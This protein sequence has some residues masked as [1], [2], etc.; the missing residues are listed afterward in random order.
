LER[1][2]DLLTI[3]LQRAN[4]DLANPHSSVAEN[5][6]KIVGADLASH[7]NL[8]DV[9]R[10]RMVVKVDHPAW[11]Q[12]LQM[13]QRQII[14]EVGRRYPQLGVTR[15]TSVLGK[16]TPARGD[17]PA[18]SPPTRPVPDAEL[19][20]ALRALSEQL[21]RVDGSEDQSDDAG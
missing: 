18:S 2:G 21:H 3:L 17:E 5:W 16:G 12:L 8:A 14:A 1:A 19:S 10:G 11:L 7:A 9:D 20:L 13:R 15:M 6:R 4:I